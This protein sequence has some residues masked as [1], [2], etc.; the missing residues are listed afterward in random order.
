MTKHYL[1]AADAD[2]IQDFV[3]RSA[4]LQEVIGGSHLLSRFCAEDEGLGA[5]SAHYAAK[6]YKGNWVREKQWGVII[7]DGGRFLLWFD[8]H[9]RAQ[10]FGNDLVELYRRTIEGSL[11]IA[12]ATEDEGYNP[13]SEDEFKAANE[14]IECRLKQA[15]SDTRGAKPAIHVPQI[16][17][18]ASCG[19]ALALEH[20]PLY[21]TPMYLCSS[22]LNKR[23]ERDYLRRSLKGKKYFINDFRHAIVDDKSNGFSEKHLWLPVK[24]VDAISQFDPRSYVAYL[25]ADGNSM[26]S[27]FHQ[28][29]TRSRMRALSEKLRAVLYHT[30]SK[31]VGLLKQRL[32]PKFGNQKCKAKEDK[33][34]ELKNILPVVP[35]ILGGDDVF[36]LLPAPYAVDFTKRF[37]EAFETEMGKALK[38]DEIKLSGK[39][40]LSAVV[41]I[42]KSNYPYKLAHQHGEELLKRAKRMAKTFAN[43]PR[44]EPRSVIDVEVILSSERRSTEPDE[45]TQGG[46]ESSLRPFWA[47]GD[48]NDAGIPIQHLLAARKDLDKLPNKRLAQL[49]PLYYSHK[50]PRDKRDSLAEWNRELEYLLGR[51]KRMEASGA[52]ARPASSGQQDDQDSLEKKLRDVLAKLGDE[53]VRGESGHWKNVTRGP[54]AFDANALP[55]L[56][57]MW[58]YCYDLDVPYED[59]Q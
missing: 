46:Y 48:P 34:F 41:V 35:L 2:K 21:E 17:F 10:E 39:P 24:P 44:N 40:T 8:N 13:E 33:S 27:L 5:L 31:P 53:N 51:V 6:K 49:R 20:V 47:N 28:C 45:P 26:G 14:K 59:Y 55:D 1:L 58:D 37:I 42:C 3:F 11:T 50:L 23:D 9:K 52:N 16:A 12:V 22:C 54:E 15:K 36:V 19:I 29:E 43:E 18:C 56:L 7:N 57:T 4:Y 32:E 25:V 30:L 38:S